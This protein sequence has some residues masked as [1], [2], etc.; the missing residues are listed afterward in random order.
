MFIN[1]LTDK[2]MFLDIKEFIDIFMYFNKIIYNFFKKNI[3]K[4]YIP[5]YILKYI[6]SID[7]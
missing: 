5:E 2:Y 1:S 3:Q 6:I 4:P 7:Y